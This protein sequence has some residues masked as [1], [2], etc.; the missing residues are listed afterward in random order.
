LGRRQIPLQFEPADNS[1]IIRKSSAYALTFFRNN[2]VSIDMH[3]VE[4]SHDT[5]FVPT[6]VTPYA[7]LVAS[8]GVV[9]MD[10]TDWDSD[11]PNP[12][13]TIVEDG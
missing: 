9:A 11:S 12:A 7:P 1:R 3:H 8:G 5:K 6:H 2:G 10:D 4:G 13:Y